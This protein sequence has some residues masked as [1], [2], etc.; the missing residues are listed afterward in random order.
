MTFWLARRKLRYL[1]KFTLDK[2]KKWK[3]C[4][5]GARIFS[6]FQNLHT[7]PSGDTAVCTALGL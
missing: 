2:T 5:H 1:Y 6:I 3:R 7:C 4:V